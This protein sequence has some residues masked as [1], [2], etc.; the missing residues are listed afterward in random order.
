MKK[1]QSDVVAVKKTQSE[2][3]AF[4]GD[5]RNFESMMPEQVEDWKA[6]ADSCSFRIKGMADLAMKIINRQPESEIKL[7]SEG[8][9]PFYFTLTFTVQPDTNEACTLQVQMDAELNALLE[10]LASEPLR[11]FLNLMA[12]KCSEGLTPNPSQ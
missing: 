8:K 1:I 7:E 4:L 10:A 2:L 6:E 5:I 9:K 12:A 11:N 3:Y